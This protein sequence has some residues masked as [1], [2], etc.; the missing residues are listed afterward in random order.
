VKQ[1]EIVILDRYLASLHVVNGATANF[2][3]CCTHSCGGPW[4]VGDTHSSIVCCSPETTTKCL[5]QE[6]SMLCQR[7]KEQN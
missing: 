1:A 6:A 5:W 4:Q 3:K 2:A 7:Q